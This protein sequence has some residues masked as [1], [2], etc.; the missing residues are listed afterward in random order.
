MRMRGMRY[1][2]A[3]MGLVVLV[4]LYVIP[5]AT[6]FRVSVQNIG[7]KPALPFL[8]VPSI[9]AP[10]V[11]PVPKLHALSPLP[12]SSLSQPGTHPARA[13]TPSHAA[14]HGVPVVN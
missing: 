7:S 9:G 2:W 8:V 3:G 5:I 4:L 14:R 1:W 10:P 13:A 11:I 6:A 12:A